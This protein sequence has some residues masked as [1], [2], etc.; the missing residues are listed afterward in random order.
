MGLGSGKNSSWI[1]GSKKHRIL[2]PDPQHC[3]PCIGNKKVKQTKLPHI[4]LLAN[5]GKASTSHLQKLVR[6]R[7]R[8][9][10]GIAAIIADIAAGRKGWNTKFSVKCYAK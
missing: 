9:E 1:K 6:I 10:E 5:I 2:D 7:E 3:I 8:E 4:P